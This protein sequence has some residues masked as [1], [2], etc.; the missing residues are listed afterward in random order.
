[1]TQ[2]SEGLRILIASRCVAR[3]PQVL[4]WALLFFMPLSACSGEAA[5]LDGPLYRE[6][7]AS[8]EGVIQAIETCR[9]FS[10]DWDGWLEKRK[11][12]GWTIERIGETTRPS[13]A[14]PNY[15]KMASLKHGDLAIEVFMDRYSEG[16][17]GLRGRCDVV[18]KAASSDEITKI[19]KQ[20]RDK[21]TRIRP[22][23]N[24]ITYLPD[25]ERLGFNQQMSPPQGEPLDLYVQLGFDNTVLQMPTN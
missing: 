25:N 5:A 2:N 3:R 21:M 8:V 23:W 20:V 24:G 6:K 15:H 19:S 12:D 14:S 22:D 9:G 13:M 7:L 18:L 10:E 4:I 16:L 17:V 11:L 1:M